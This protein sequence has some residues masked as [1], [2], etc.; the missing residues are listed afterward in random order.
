MQISI[1]D[2][3][4]QRQCHVKVATGP[5]TSCVSRGEA[6]T[7]LVRALPQTEPEQ[8]PRVQASYLA[9]DLRC[10]SRVKG[11][12]ADRG[13][14]RSGHRYVQLGSVL[15]GTLGV[16]LKGTPHCQYPEGEEVG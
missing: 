2:G 8:R 10:Q 12:E 7:V 5:L 3:Q 9:G 16:T 14:L 4:C 11:R 13:G 6:F 1:S 15:L